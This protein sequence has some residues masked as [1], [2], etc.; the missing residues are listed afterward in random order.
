MKRVTLL[1]VTRMLSGVCIG[2]IDEDGNWVRPVKEFGTLL[3]GDITYPTREVMRVFDEAGFPV[4]RPRPQGAH[5]EDCVSDFVRA[6]PRCLRR[7]S[8][9]ERAAFLARHAEPDANAVL[10]DQQRSLC[11]VRCRTLEALFTH[12]TYT[13]K[14]GARVSVDGERSLPVTDLRWRALG[15]R[16]L[17]EKGGERRFSAEALAREIGAE[18]IYVAYGLSRE[19]QGQIWR[20]VVGIHPVPDFD[21][22]LDYRRM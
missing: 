9:D 5:V 20:L 18:E 17:G 2:G 22:T 8:A 15:R 19:Y 3:L 10:R 12:D 4:L 21:I 13:G 14:L 1:A 6:R 16:I 11:L 7:L